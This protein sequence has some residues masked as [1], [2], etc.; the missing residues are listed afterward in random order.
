MAREIEHKFLVR[1]DAWRPLATSSQLLRQGYL[2]SGDSAVVRVRTL[3]DRDAV[4][5]IK[6]ANK[7]LSRAE[8]EYAIP[9]AD[10][11][12]LLR[13]CGDKVIEKRRHDIPNGVDR[14]QVDVFGGRLEGL[15]LAELELAHEGQSFE[16]PDWLGEEVT[17]D[18]RYYNNR[19]AEDGLPV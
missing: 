1:G 6:S 3:G 10:G 11:R 18:P 9:I 16:R 15:I 14:W 17:G 4:I 8:F 5:T 13:M 12:E 7:G 19:L 2:A